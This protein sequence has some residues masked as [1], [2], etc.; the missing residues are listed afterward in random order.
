MDNKRGINT[1]NDAA[2]KRELLKRL[3]KE[4]K[5]LKQTDKPT[6]TKAK[7]CLKKRPANLQY[8]PLSFAQ[9][10]LWLVDKVNPGK[11]G[12]NT[13]L[14]LLLKGKLDLVAL[15]QTFET[16]QQRHEV[17]RTC[18]VETDDFVQSD[19]EE[20]RASDDN[21][22][23]VAVI[24]EKFNLPLTEIDLSQEND[25]DSKLEN[26]LQK[27]MESPFD[28]SRAPLYRAVLI[29]INETD[30][31]LILTVHHII[32]DGW[33]TAVLYAEFCSI[34]QAYVEDR[35]VSQTPD[36]QYLDYAIAQ[37]DYLTKGV[38]EKQL[39]YWK[40]QLADAPQLDLPKDN[41]RTS[42]AGYH[43]RSKSR[44]IP[45]GLSKAIRMLSQAEGVTVFATMLSVF[46]L[47]MHR[48]SGQDDIVIGTPLMIRNTPIWKKLSGC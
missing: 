22:H 17:L 12:Y 6:A 11:A 5:Q 42:S 16:L 35:D 37:R 21:A 38:L 28:L 20:M 27:E 44:K 43:G 1:P 23:I 14:T 2:Q 18:F 31:R 36:V 29:R 7:L 10:A 8:L 4:E 48:Y 13:M 24:H 47:L 39:A 15:Y 30:H 45:A 40:Q 3:L 32:S 41:A 9:E 25:V 19:E 34:Y 33:S 46:N 26:A